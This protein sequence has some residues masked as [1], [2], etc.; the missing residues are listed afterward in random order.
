MR[1]DETSFLDTNILVYAAD[2]ESPFHSEARHLVNRA[3]AGELRVCISP[4][5][6]GELYAT[7]TSLRKALHPLPPGE[8]VEQAKALWEKSQKI[9]P[10][11]G[12]LGL[13]LDL[14]QRYELRGADFF[15]AREDPVLNS[16]LAETLFIDNKNIGKNELAKTLRSEHHILAIS[17]GT[18]EDLN[19][20]LA[21]TTFA[22]VFKEVD[23]VI[24]RG[25]IQKR[26]LFETKFRFTQDIFNISA[27]P[28]GAVTVSFKARHRDVIKFAHADLDRKARAI[29]ARMEE[30]KNRG[31][32]VMFYSG[33]IGSI[34]GKLDIAKKVMAVFVSFLKEQSAMTFIINPSEHF[35]PGMDADDLM[36]MWEIVQSSGLIDIWRFQS[37]EDITTA[38]RL[39]GMKIPPEW[40]GKDATYS[41]GCTK[42]MRI[43][44][45]VQKRY[46]EMQ[47]IGPDK[48]KLYDRRL[49][50]I[51]QMH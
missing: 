42:E 35:E 48:E 30:A 33:I 2:T 8:A 1:I 11:P 3:N 14:V 23:A 51:S 19:L 13:T 40:V 36:Y 43:A 29:I 22:R 15:D 31:M 50:D 46:P 18:S 39:L 25:E 38:F 27:D 47:I 32:T 28:D 26:R 16:E 5:V 17:D 37:Y 7:L 24:S 10:K 21:S 41:T 6:I 12:T 9:Y 20:I 4:Q 45:Q 34:P 49:S 44:L